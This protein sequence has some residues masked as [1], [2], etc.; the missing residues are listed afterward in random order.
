[1][2]SLIV[3]LLWQEHVIYTLIKIIILKGYNLY[4][5]FTRADELQY[6]STM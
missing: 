6:K 4:Q 1:M 5:M 2:G 3:S